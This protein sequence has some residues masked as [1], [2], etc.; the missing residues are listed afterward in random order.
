MLPDPWL[1]LG[2]F[3]LT[4]YTIE[5]IT[6][7][8]SI[9]IALSLGALLLP[10]PQL[11]PVLVPL[12]MVMTGFLVV[13]HRRDLDLRLLLGLILPLM[14]TGTV[15]G[16]LLVPWLGN[17]SLQVVLGGLLVWFAG[18]QLWMIHHGLSHTPHPPLITR[19][20]VFS[21]GI[22]HGLFASGGPLLVY[23]MAGIARSK[24]RFRATLLAVWFIL[25]T[26]L[27][28]LYLWD[29]TLL[30]NLDRT[31]LYLPLL[32]LGILIGNRVHH[33]LNEEHFKIVVFTLLG[34]TGMALV[35]G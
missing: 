16:Y 32:I 17:H 7:F 2:L 21:A 6:G 9:V 25:N 28:V 5:T 27:S 3:I 18:R 24:T 26:T 15:A 8:G 35:F 30:A 10:I 19:G 11:L 34:V 4:A 1:L 29:G 31:V 14:L 22:T 20:L 23:A 12:N 33:W 13:Q